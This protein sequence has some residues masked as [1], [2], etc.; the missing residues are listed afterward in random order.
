MKNVSHIFWKNTTTRSFSSWSL[1]D[2]KKTLETLGIHITN[3]SEENLNYNF[4]PKIATLKK[5]FSN[6]ETKILILKR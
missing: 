1:I 2:K 6:M 5:P 4:K 3:N